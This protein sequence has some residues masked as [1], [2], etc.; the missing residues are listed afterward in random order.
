MRFRW[1]KYRLKTRR[2]DRIGLALGDDAIDFGIALAEQPNRIAGGAQRALGSL[3]VGGCLLH[4]FLRDCARLI[5]FTQARQ[6]SGGELQYARRG[7]Q[8]RLGLQKVWAVDGEQRLPP[9]H[10]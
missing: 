5:E 10:G 1:T 4:I 9:L 7:Y 6:I 8:S 2:Q 3:L